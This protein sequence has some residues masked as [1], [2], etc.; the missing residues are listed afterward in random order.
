[1]S[2]EIIVKKSNVSTERSNIIVPDFKDNKVNLGDEPRK[3]KIYVTNGKKKDGSTFAKVTGYAICNIYEGIED[4]AKYVRTGVK[5]FSVHFKKVAFQGSANVHNVEELK[6]GYLYVKAKGLRIPSNYKLKYKRNK[7][8]EII[9]DDNGEALIQYPEIWVE[10]GVLGLE[11]FVISQSALNVDD[12]KD[13]AID[14]K[15]ED[16]SEDED[17]SEAI[18]DDPEDD[19]EVNI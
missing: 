14:V 7:E 4:E 6:S 10:E 18:V 2:N 17:I 11:E 1:M 5:G 8:K 12:V 3:L 9:Y 16:V 13:E 19:E 15:P